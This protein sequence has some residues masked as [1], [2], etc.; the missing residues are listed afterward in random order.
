MSASGPRVRF[1][2]SPTGQL[3]VGNART[4]LFNWLIARGQQGTFLLRI[5]DTDF[6]R[7]TAESDRSVLDD[8]RWLGLEWE[9][10]VEAGGAYGPYRQSERLG[11]YREHADRLL[12]GGHGYY[13]FCSPERLEAEREAAMAAGRPPM[14]AGTCR[15]IA[16]ADARARIAAGE[17]ASIRL[18]V[19]AHREV[20]FD[21]L[22]RGTVRFETEVIGDP[23]VVRS[24]GVPAYNFAV[25]VDDALMDITLVVRGEDHISNTPRQILLYEAFGYAL[26]QF[27]HVSMVLGPDHTKLSKRHGATSVR[28]FRERGILPEALVNYLA[29][30]GWSPGEN[31]ELLPADELAGRFRI[32]HVAHS[33]GVFDPEKLAWVN[34]HYLKLASP[35][36]LAALAAP[37]VDAAGWGRP[38][39]AADQGFLEALMAGVVTSIDC[40][41]DVPERVR[42]LFAFNAASA[43]AVPGVAEELASPVARAVVLAFA[44]ELEACGPLSDRELFRAAATRVRQKTGAKGKELFHPIRL[45]VT[46][47]PSGMELDH[48]VPLIELAAALP[49]DSMFARVP[50]AA[51]RAR[52]MATAVGSA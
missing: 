49:A 21:D 28:E 36:R 7:S 23:V 2:P 42:F 11:I 1:A 9:E 10:G 20:A 16:L 41:A 46:G 37:F 51:A 13:C 4:A 22:V 8:L 30:L 52:A 6:D 40:L 29:L 15:G 44:D 33:A 47:E 39:S 27:A 18:R 34:R 26:P 14:Y 43:L 24:D 3:H 38:G 31:E 32:E 25:V 35:E 17:P 50:S 5:E 45:A 48:A 19:P 12:D